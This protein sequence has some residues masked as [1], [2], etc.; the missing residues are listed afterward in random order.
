MSAGAKQK[1][2]QYNYPGNVREL[3]AVIELA[4]VMSDGKTIEAHDI[5]LF[6]TALS[7]HFIHSKTEKTLRQYSVDIINFYMHK[8][9]NN[10]VEVAQ[11]L[12]IGKSTIYNMIQAGEIKK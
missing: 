11:R 4:M 8:Y 5:S 2:L 6:P 9:D 7:D 12:D 3:K 1:L 10:V